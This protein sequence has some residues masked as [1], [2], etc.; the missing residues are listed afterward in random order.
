MVNR[1]IND[2]LDKYQRYR[3][4]DV[5]AYRKKK[6]EWARSPEQRKLR[7][8][9]MRKWR[10]KNRARN[11]E[12]CRQSQKRNRHKHIARNWASH[13]KRKYGLTIQDYAA[14]LASQGN[15]CALC[16]GQFKNKRSTHVDHCHKTGKVRGIL[17][18]ACNTMLGRVE[19]ATVKRVAEYLERA[20]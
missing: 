11:N 17:C 13:L 12:I 1:V 15:C 10:E 3:L 9:Y 7:T 19:R 2:G 16:L 6:A 20:P 8:E 5:D 18:T 14:M 4:K